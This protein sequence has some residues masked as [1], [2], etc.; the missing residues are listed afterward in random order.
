MLAP[1]L[2]MIWSYLSLKKMEILFHLLPE[3]VELLKLLTEDLILD[4]LKSIQL[5]RSL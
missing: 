1:I 5:E 3:H 4:T 2:T